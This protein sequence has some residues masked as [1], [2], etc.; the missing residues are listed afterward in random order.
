MLVK[1]KS[2]GKSEIILE[3][4]GNFRQILFVIFLVIFKCTVY[5]LLKWISF[6]NFKKNTGKMKKKILE[7]SGNFVS[8]ETW[9]QWFIYS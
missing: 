3:N 7:M 9:E 5:H 8:P 6:Q 4:S 2:Q 1:L